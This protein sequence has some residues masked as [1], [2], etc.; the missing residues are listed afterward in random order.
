MTSSGFLRGSEYEGFTVKAA[1]INEYIAIC[2]LSISAFK[3]KAKFHKESE[4]TIT[5]FFAQGTHLSH[6]LQYNMD[7]QKEYNLIKI[8]AKS[9]TNYCPKTVSARYE[10]FGILHIDLMLPYLK[11][12]Q[13][14]PF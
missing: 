8:K 3:I 11:G 9:V 10:E 4:S 2:E 14:K 1:R 5:N 6:H 12:L 7:I 13:V